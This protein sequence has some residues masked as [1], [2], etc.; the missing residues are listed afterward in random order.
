MK[1]SG[2]LPPPRCETTI[3]RWPPRPQL[4]KT[5]SPLSSGGDHGG[6]RV[7]LVRRIG[8][9]QAGRTLRLLAL[10]GSGCL[11]KG[12]GND[13]KEAFRWSFQHE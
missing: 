10:G 12:A 7:G 4:P 13:K 6:R 2:Q 5:R 8:S 9:P 1:Y 11:A 3:R